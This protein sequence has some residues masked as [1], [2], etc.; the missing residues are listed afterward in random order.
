MRNKLYILALISS[1]VSYSPAAQAQYTSELERTEIIKRAETKIKYL[2]NLLNTI[3]NG[4]YNREYIEKCIISSYSDEEK[5]FS[6]IFVDENVQIEDDLK[7]E[8]LGLYEM[9]ASSREVGRYL[10]DFNLYY[11]KGFTETVSFSKIKQKKIINEDTVL[12]V[13]SFIRSFK[14]MH[15]SFNQKEYPDVKREITL[16]AVYNQTTYKWDVLIAGISFD[17]R[18]YDTEPVA[19]A[20]TKGYVKLSSDLVLTEMSEI[21]KRLRGQANVNLAFT[22]VF[23]EKIKRGKTIYLSWN[24]PVKN[25]NLRLFKNGKYIKEFKTG[26]NGQQ[27]AWKVKLSPGRKYTVMLYDPSTRRATVSEFFR[28]K[29]RT[30]I[31]FFTVTMTLAAVMGYLEYSETIDLLPGWPVPP[32]IDIAPRVPD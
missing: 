25:A 4:G 29:K 13:M 30:P 27:Y 16:R 20:E 18:K 7:P 19:F 24:S 21:D 28:V 23:P 1:L 22:T 11:L 8:V 14:G 5:L 15:R 17:R 32:T 2:A 3:S 6:R 12:V 9:D 10:Q 31:S 26:L